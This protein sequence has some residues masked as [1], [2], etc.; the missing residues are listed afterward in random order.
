MSAF[1]ETVVEEATL[2]WL[3]H[4]GYAIKH[5]AGDSEGMMR[6]FYE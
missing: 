3:E 1:Y 6:N 2:A 5:A 4:L